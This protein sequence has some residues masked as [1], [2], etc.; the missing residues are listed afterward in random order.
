MPLYVVN[1]YKE[2][3]STGADASTRTQG[4]LLILE[5]IIYPLIH[6]PTYL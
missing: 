4:S 6:N 3:L 1:R 5:V 2:M